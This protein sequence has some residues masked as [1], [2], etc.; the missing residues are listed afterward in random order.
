MPIGAAGTKIENFGQETSL[1]AHNSIRPLSCDILCDNNFPVPPPHLHV[2]SLLKF[3][4]LLGLPVALANM[5]Q[6]RHCKLQ[7]N[8]S[9]LF[10]IYTTNININSIIHMLFYALIL[11]CFTISDELCVGYLCCCF[12]FCNIQC[13]KAVFTEVS[14]T[15]AFELR[16]ERITRLVVN[17]VYC[18]EYVLWILVLLLETCCDRSIILGDFFR[19]FTY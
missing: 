14:F 3:F 17:F 6:K 9:R 2:C 4:G 10:S 15:N 18:F 8:F 12:S 16:K 7:V 11:S 13:F 1:F 19:S 5:K